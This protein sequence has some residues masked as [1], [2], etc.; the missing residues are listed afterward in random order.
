MVLIAA[1]L[2]NVARLARWAGD[3]AAGD[4]LVAILHFAF[5]FVPI[6]FVLSGLAAFVPAVP[7][8]AGIHAWGV[9]AIGGMTLA[10]M[11]RASLGHTG[12]ALHAGWGTKF[13]YAAVLLA[14]ATRIWAALAPQES[15]VLLHVAA[16]AW[17]AAF[18]GFALVYGPALL[19]PRLD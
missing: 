7:A 2:L 18:L 9:G 10:V 8:S 5:L 11:T 4:P 3:R 19:R 1:G 16:F 13:V 17:V 6:G 15:F 12:R 14:A